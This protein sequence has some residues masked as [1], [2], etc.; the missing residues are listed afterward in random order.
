MGA[1]PVPVPP[2]SPVVTKT[3]SAPSRASMILSASSRAALRPTSGLAPAPSPLVSLTP[4]WI[5][6]GARESLSA[7]RSVLATTNSMPSRWDSIMRLTALP[8]PPPTPM[9]LIL[10]LF[11]T[12]SLNWMRMSFSGCFWL[13]SSIMVT[14]VGLKPARQNQESLSSARLKPCPFKTSVLDAGLK[15]S[16]TYYTFCLANRAFRRAPSPRSTLVRT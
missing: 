5:L 14:S 15:A 4:S 13:K 9:T 8:P 11:S 12:S 6:T 3:M 16:S 2:P 1:A 10:A 7:C